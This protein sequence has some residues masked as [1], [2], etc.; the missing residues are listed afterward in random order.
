VRSYL[1][2]Q[3]GDEI[4]ISVRTVG[5]GSLEATRRRFLDVI[6]RQCGALDEAK[7]RLAPLL[8]EPYT[9]AGKRQYVIL[10]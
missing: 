1:I 4:E 5:D 6:G 8:R 9:V 10:E 7:L 2:R 3:T